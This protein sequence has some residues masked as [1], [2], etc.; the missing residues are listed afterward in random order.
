M[1][2]QKSIEKQ[3]HC[4]QNIQC[5]YNRLEELNRAFTLKILELQ[6]HQNRF[7]SYMRSHKLFLG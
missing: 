7:E 6:E 2:K 5:Q 4:F 1:K 3:V